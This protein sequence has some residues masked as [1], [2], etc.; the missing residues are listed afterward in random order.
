MIK[1]WICSFVTLILLLNEIPIFSN[2]AFNEGYPTSGYKISAPSY[3]QTLEVNVSGRTDATP[4]VVWTQTD[5]QIWTATFAD[6]VVETPNV[7]KGWDAL[8]KSKETAEKIDMT[9]YVP[10]SMRDTADNKYKREY[11]RNLGIADMN[12][13]RADSYSKVDAKPDFKVGEITANIKVITGNLQEYNSKPQYSTQ[14]NGDP[15]FNAHY[16]I[17][18]DVTFQG[19]IVEKKQIRV[20]ESAALNINDTKD[21]IAQVRTLEYSMSD[22]NDKWTTVTT[23]T[24]W[25]SSDPSVATIDANG[26]VTAK[27]RERQRLARHGKNSLMSLR[28][29][30]LLQ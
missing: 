19:T 3:M 4:K 6:G 10:D 25:Q 28:Q 13:I 21:M 18:M 20:L 23:A 1:K 8:P 24:E 22:W 30:L 16:W 9:V 15:K 2:A 17:P 7:G 29:Q 11:I 26:K 14:P 12:W 5:K 27:K